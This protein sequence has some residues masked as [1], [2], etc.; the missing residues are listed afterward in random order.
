LLGKARSFIEKF[1]HV[2]FYTDYVHLQTRNQE[3][4]QR[5]K[6]M[7]ICL[8]ENEKRIVSLEIETKEKGEMLRIKTAMLKDVETKTGS[9]Y[10]YA[11]ETVA[12]WYLVDEL[13]K[14]EAFKKMVRF[15][16]NEIEEREQN[17]AKGEEH[18]FWFCQGAKSVLHN[19]LTM[20]E[21]IK[22]KIEYL[23]NKDKTNAD[24]KAVPEMSYES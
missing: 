16:A 12:S 8:E 13:L 2:L 11:A 17:I 5:I 4:T 19:M 10:Y 23:K 22:K 20:N 15:M 24:T 18:Q 14:A 21:I 9:F 1:F 7:L 3:M 6:D